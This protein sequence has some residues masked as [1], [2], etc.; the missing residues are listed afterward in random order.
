[1]RTFLDCYPCFLRQAIEAA[2]MSE[3]TPAQEKDIVLS[4]LEILQGIED[5]ATPPVIGTKV[6]QLVR[7]ITGNPDPYFQVK[8]EATEKALRMVPELQSLLDASE[9]RLATALRLSIAGNI[10]DFGPNPDYDLWDIVDQVL[11]EELAIDDTEILLTRLRDVNSV[12]FLADNAGETVFDRLLIEELPKPVTYA[13]RGGAVINDATMADA[14]AAGID[15]VA[16][17]IDNGSR[18]PGTILSMCSQGFQEIFNTAE[19]IFSKGMGNYE[20]LSEVHS[21]IL[22]LM[23]V[24]CHVIAADVGAPTNSAVIKKGIGLS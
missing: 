18:V 2:R 5:G 12:L 21:P 15:Q 6:H 20:T 7:D 13:V 8:K 9:D 1:M 22:F 16:E 3:A 17:V 24:K 10:I 14:I 11:N 23:R 19:L 4:I